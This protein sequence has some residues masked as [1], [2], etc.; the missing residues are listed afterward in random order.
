MELEGKVALVTGAGRGLGR[1]TALALAEQGAR[2]AALARSLP[3]VEET[4]RLI[5]QEYGVGRAIA[6][7]ADVSSERDVTL[8]FDTIRKRWGGVD[9]L[10]NNAGNMGATRPISS[11]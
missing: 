4:A 8:A 3:Q 5:R 2:V 1:A 6:I 7:R 10:V 11:L 9:I